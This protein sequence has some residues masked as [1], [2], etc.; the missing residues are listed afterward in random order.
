MQKYEI[1]SKF[2]DW[3]AITGSQTVQNRPLVRKKPF[4]W[5]WTET[6]SLISR[7]KRRIPIYTMLNCQMAFNRS[8]RVGGRL[9]SVYPASPRRFRIWS[10]SSYHVLQHITH[11]ALFCLFSLCALHRAEAWRSEGLQSFLHKLLQRVCCETL[12]PAL[13]EPSGRSVK[14]CDNKPVHLKGWVRFKARETRTPAWSWW[15]GDAIPGSPFLHPWLQPAS[16]SP[17]LLMAICAKLTTR[18]IEHL[19]QCAALYIRCPGRSPD[20]Y[21]KSGPSILRLPV[22]AWNQ[23]LRFSAPPSSV[24]FLPSSV[25][26]LPFSV[27]FQFPTWSGIWY[28][29][30]RWGIEELG[31]W[32]PESINLQS[33]RNLRL[34]KKVIYGTKISS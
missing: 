16:L 13:T 14:S 20:A 4:P 31:N 21:F 18:F 30:K 23:A 2:W 15:H 33:N 11:P 6:N 19:V 22:F 28:T 29:F 26:R 3:I 5:I 7:H 8:S 34:L 25:F 17:I 1:W 27:L 32:I 12:A 9:R 10:F 24:L